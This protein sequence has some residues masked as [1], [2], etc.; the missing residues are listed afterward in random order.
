M[1]VASLQKYQPY[2]G[3]VFGPL[4]ESDNSEIRAILKHVDRILLEIAR[5]FGRDRAGWEGTGLELT[6]SQSGQTVISC[7]VGAFTKKGNCIEFC[8]QLHPSWHY[9]ELSDVPAWD[10]EASIE[11]D[12]MHTVDCSHMHTVDES[13]V[14]VGTAVGATKELLSTVQN[15]RRKATEHPLEYW[16][17]FASDDRPPTAA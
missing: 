12:C 10:I 7:N 4:S 13:V 1:E 14:R 8:V 2:L 11:A 5:H 17:E 6:W 15:L 16:L 9:G 3:S